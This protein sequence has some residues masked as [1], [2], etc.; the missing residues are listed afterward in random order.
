MHK[1]MTQCNRQH[2]VPLNKEYLVNMFYVP[3]EA[4]FPCPEKVNVLKGIHCSEAVAI[5]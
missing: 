1:Y 2:T 4:M 3:I 5:G